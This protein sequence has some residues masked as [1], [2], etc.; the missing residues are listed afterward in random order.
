MAYGS[1]IYP[2][3]LKRFDEFPFILSCL[4]H[5]HLLKKPSLS[6]VGARNASFNSCK[7]TERI[8]RELGE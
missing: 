5:M 7:Y 6:I 3:H 4:G 1:D 8:S 2:E